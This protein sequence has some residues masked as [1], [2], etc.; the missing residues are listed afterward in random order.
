LASNTGHR[1]S[2]S[3]FPNT[4][5]APAASHILYADADNASEAAAILATADVPFVAIPTDGFMEP[6]LRVGR[7]RLTGLDAIRTF[8][9]QF[10]ASRGCDTP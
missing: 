3:G 6:E 5:G 8:A 4:P 10:K 7:L 9:K 1:A 2:S